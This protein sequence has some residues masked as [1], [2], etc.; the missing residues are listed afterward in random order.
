MNLFGR[1]SDDPGRVTPITRRGSRHAPGAAA[2]T[3]DTHS[4][5]AFPEI[6]GLPQVSDLPDLPDLPDPAQQGATPVPTRLQRLAAV[7]DRARPGRSSRNVRKWLE[8]IGM[9]LIVLGF[10]LILLG[11]YGAAHSPYLY[12]E[13]PYLISGGLLGVALVIGG[14]V[15]VHCA[16]CMRKVEED[17]RNALAIVRSVDRLERIMRNLDD[18]R[19]GEQGQAVQAGQAAQAVQEEHSR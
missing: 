6:P 2:T 10:V 15:L 19:R 1:P 9:V 4:T 3:G 8:T 13:V 14:G 11:W 5:A 7:V 16:W 17:R 18:S 12:Q